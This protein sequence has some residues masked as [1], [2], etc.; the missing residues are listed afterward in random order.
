MIDAQGRPL[1][2]GDTVAVPPPDPNDLWVNEFSGT[3]DSFRDPHTV[4][5][6]D[7]DGDHWDIDADRL[8]KED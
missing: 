3:V 8:T 7:G 1:N 6:V 2:I 5:I 4:D